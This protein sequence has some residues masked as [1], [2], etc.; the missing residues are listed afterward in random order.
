MGILT[1][2]LHKLVF[3]GILAGEETWACSIYMATQGAEVSEDG[4]N[5][6]A[7]EQPIKDWFLR[8][9]SGINQVARLDYLKCNQVNKADGK[10]VNQAETFQGFYEPPVA[11]DGGMLV[12]P[13]QIS[14]ALTWHT[15]KARGR[16]SKGRIYPPSTHGQ[17]LGTWMG[18]DGLLNQN[19]ALG[20]ADSAQELLAEL[21]NATTNLTAVVWSQI[22][23]EAR[24]IERVSCGRTVD[25]QLRRRRNLPEA[26]V[27]ATAAV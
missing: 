18:P 19:Y 4:G 12:A 24:A 11:A 13:P 2:N 23:Q 27:F 26:R 22:A 1:G 5:V 21:N 17:G 8:I 15:D 25:T 7:F 14:T 3:G 10:Y 20:M 16:N 9:P 6:L